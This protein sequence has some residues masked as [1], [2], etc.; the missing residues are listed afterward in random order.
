MS[1][2]D[3]TR[4]SAPEFG[5]RPP[6]APRP[7]ATA[8]VAPAEPVRIGPSVEE[9]AAIE[10]AARDE[11]YA[12]GHK[13]GLAA[14]QTEVQR[15]HK[16]LELLVQSLGAPFADLDREVARVLGQVAVAIAGELLGE[17]YQADPERLDRLVDSAL[18]AVADQRS[19]A[20]VHMH[21]QDLALINKE[22]DRGHTRLLADSSLKRGDVRVHTATL[23]LDATVQS[24]LEAALAALV[25]ADAEPGA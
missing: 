2:Q 24:R 8:P 14:G 15:L 11:G 18:A 1:Q 20:E 5:A 10:K 22:I 16:Q 25:Q 4:W 12:E 9:L 17:A 23:R 7:A 19:N 13:Q 21:P 3:A 6:V